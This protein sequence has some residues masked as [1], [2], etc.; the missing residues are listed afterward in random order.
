M[1][2]DGLVV[3][4]G[5][6]DFPASSARWLSRDRLSTANDRQIPPESGRIQPFVSVCGLVV[7]QP[8][9]VWWSAQDSNQQRDRKSNPPEC[10]SNFAPKPTNCYPETIAPIS[11]STAKPSPGFP[12]IQRNPRVKRDFHGQFQL[13]RPALIPFAEVRADLF[14]RPLYP[15]K[16]T[17]GRLGREVRL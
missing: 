1:P 15:Q 7:L 9:I 13:F 11:P 16:R 12:R 17:L 2:I 3:E 4:T 14:E 8:T 6:R 5:A 10:L